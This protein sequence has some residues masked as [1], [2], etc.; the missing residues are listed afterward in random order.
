M[1][2]ATQ[3]GR[4]MLR[5]SCKQWTDLGRLSCCVRV[6][7]RAYPPTSQPTIATQSVVA[8]CCAKLKFQP[9]RR[10][11]ASQMRSVVAELQKACGHPHLLQDF[12]P[13][14]A[15]PLAR[16]IAASGKLRVLDALLARLRAAGQRVLL[17]CH[18]NAVR[19]ACSA[20]WFCA[21]ARCPE[22]GRPW[23]QIN[24]FRIDRIDQQESSDAMGRPKHYPAAV[25]RSKLQLHAATLPRHQE[26]AEIASADL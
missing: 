2:V 11:R 5:W 25:K 6:S 15:P 1:Q 24:R 22:H 16:R 4:S 13:A 20:C 17:L 10:D 3:L 21:A 14:D 9:V 26:H 7:I 8:R 23:A 19:G 18:S 12:R